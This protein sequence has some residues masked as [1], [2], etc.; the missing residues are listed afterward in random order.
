MCNYEKIGKKTNK[1][2]AEGL[3]LNLFFPF[4]QNINKM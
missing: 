4:G 2:K 1:K 3:F